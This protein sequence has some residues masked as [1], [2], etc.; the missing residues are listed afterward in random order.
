MSIDMLWIVWT[1]L[2]RHIYSS[3]CVFPYFPI[4]R[5]D[6]SCQLPATY[7]ATDSLRLECPCKR[8]LMPVLKQLVH[9]VKGYSVL[10]RTYFQRSKVVNFFYEPF[11]FPQRLF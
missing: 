1:C 6:V 4:E 9:C 7:L 10:P 2:Y 5:V 3:D 11:V 8:A